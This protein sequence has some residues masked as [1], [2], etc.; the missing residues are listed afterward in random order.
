MLTAKL[1]LLN[2]YIGINKLILNTY[3]TRSILEDSYCLN[4][5]EI[6]DPDKV[7]KYSKYHINKVNSFIDENGELKDGHVLVKNIASPIN[8]ADIN[9]IQV[10]INIVF[11]IKHIIFVLKIF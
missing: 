3:S 2:R 6:G 4:F 7:I 11:L 5:E 8:P 9:Y 10:N 1:K